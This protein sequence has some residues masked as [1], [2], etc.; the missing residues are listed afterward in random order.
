MSVTDTMERL[1]NTLDK[2]DS[3]IQD[4]PLSNTQ[5]KKLAS[6]VYELWMDIEKEVA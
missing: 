3:L 1:D 4:L 6:K 5:K 2:V